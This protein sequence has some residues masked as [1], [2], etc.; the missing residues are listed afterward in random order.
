M[1]IAVILAGAFAGG[2]VSGLAGFGTGL[3]ALGIWLH[4]VKPSVAAL[5]VMSCSVVGQAQTMPTIWHAVDRTRL[6]PFILA[7][8]LGVP[9][10]TTLLA[11][12]DP[13][14]FRLAVGVFLI[15]FSG[16]MHLAK[17]RIRV[18]WGGRVA[19]GA[20]GFA[21]GVLGGMA[22]LSGPLPTMWATLRGWGK[23]ERR[24]VFQTFN[25][26]I[27]AAALASSVAA[28]RATGEFVRLALVALPGTLLGSW[29]GA[30]A[31]VRLS[32]R[33]FNGLVLLLLGISG[34]TLIWTSL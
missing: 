21:G 31:Y 8:L 13:A 6:L 15:G 22:G 24:S 32:D 16:F 28:G 33:H 9:I 18:A 30:W 12:F 27:L 25:L 34:V 29:L 10:G 1:L 11:L 7:G 23:D 20:I 26:M 4:V 19:D 17:G 3:V 2:F 5:L 14:A